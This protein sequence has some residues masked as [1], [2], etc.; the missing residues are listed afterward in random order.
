MTVHFGGVFR[1]DL[2]P[3]AAH[4]S[5]SWVEEGLSSDTPSPRVHSQAG[6]NE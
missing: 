1:V 3:A 6:V 5:V 4:A 2:R